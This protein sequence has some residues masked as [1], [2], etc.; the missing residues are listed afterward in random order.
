MQGK[1]G[2]AARE[3]RPPAAG[4]TAECPSVSRWKLLRSVKKGVRLEKKA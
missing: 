4:K 3:E 1:N 2:K